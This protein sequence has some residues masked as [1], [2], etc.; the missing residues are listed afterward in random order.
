MPEFVPVPWIRGQ[1]FRVKG[2]VRELDTGHPLPGLVVAAFDR[3]F[4][5]DD[6]LGESETDAAGRFEIH[7]TDAEFKDVIESQPDLY[8][9]VFRPGTKQPI[10]DTSY[11]VRKDAGADEHYDIA[12]PRAQLAEGAS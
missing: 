11:A 10:H 6:F 7:F 3:D 4:V 1:D 8:L 12:I 9:C 2:V 5:D